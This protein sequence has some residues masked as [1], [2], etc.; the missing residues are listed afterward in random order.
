MPDGVFVGAV[1][2]SADCGILLDL[3]NVFANGVNGRQPVEDFLAQLPLDRVWEIHLAGGFDMEGLWL[4]AHSR[5]PFGDCQAGRPSFAESES[6]Y[7]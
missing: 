5:S 2:E 3:H 7:F 1:A 6:N 4:D